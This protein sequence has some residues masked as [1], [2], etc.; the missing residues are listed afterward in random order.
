M[1]ETTIRH[2]P[3]H[4]WLA[5]RSPRWS[6]SC[7]MPIAVQFKSGDVEHQALESL[8]LCDQSATLKLSIKGPRA[9]AW[10]TEQE[11]PVPT[12]VY[13]AQ[14]LDQGSLLFRLGPDE[15]FLQGVLGD[16]LPSQLLPSPDAAA[17]DVYCLERQDATLLLSGRRAPQVLAQTCG[18]DF[19]A[20]PD[21]H[22]VFTRVAGV[23]VGVF[24]D[25]HSGYPTF[26]L[27]ADPSYA[28]DLW[29]SLVQ[30]VEPL[31]GT[32]VGLGCLHPEL[33]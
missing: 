7:G 20:Q 18:L 15:F 10:L 3:I 29:E 1:L 24:P 13:A 4:A 25:H 5:S 28:L 32:V 19:E 9:A 14:R 12:D 21:G 8:A 27:W 11:L 30:I 33:Q 26:Q 17:E 22:L 31:G 16:E 6:V 2:S 23:S